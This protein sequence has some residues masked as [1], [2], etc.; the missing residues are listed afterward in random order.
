MER[1]SK[2]RPKS[3]QTK[4]KGDTCDGTHALYEGGESTLNAFKSGLIPFKSAQGRWPKILTP[5]QMFEKLPIAYAEVQAGNIFEH[6]LYEIRQTI[7]SLYWTKKN[8]K[9]VYNNIMNSI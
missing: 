3:K 7:F 8:T 2:A 5:K 1:N 4:R 9:K 6:F